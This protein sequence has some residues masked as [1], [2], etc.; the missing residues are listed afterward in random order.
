MSPSNLSTNELWCRK[1]GKATP[2]LRLR[3]LRFPVIVIAT[4]AAQ[5][6]SGRDCPLS[7]PQASASILLSIA[8]ADGKP[9]TGIAVNLSG[10]L[11]QTM[12]CS[13]GNATAYCNWTGPVSPGTY[14]LEVTAPGYRTLRTSATVTLSHDCCDSATL[15]PSAV[16]LDPL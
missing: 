8:A 10:P 9:V 13:E 6:C 12:S 15:A 5:G 3:Q 1:A 2:A 11:A 4:V 16:T 14:T 7:C